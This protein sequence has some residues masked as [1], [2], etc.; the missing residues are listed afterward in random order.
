MFKWTLFTGMR[1][2]GSSCI[3]YCIL[4][5]GFVHAICHLSY[6]SLCVQLPLLDI[7]FIKYESL[8]RYISTH[9]QHV[10]MFLCFVKS[11]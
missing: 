9:H 3:H 4:V 11:C 7:V 2:F 10:C 1:P 5:T 6:L 8:L